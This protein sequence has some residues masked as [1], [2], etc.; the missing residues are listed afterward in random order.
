[1]GKQIGH[2]AA[3]KIPEPAPAIKL[4]FAEGLIRAHPSHIFQS[5]AWVSTGLGG[6][7]AGCS[8]ATSRFYLGDTSQAAALNQIDRVPEVGPAALLHATLQNLFA[9]ANGLRKGSAF[10][11]GVGDR[12]FQVDVFAG[13]EGVTRCVRASGPAML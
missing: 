12:F 9:G 2:A 5:S 7:V 10:F 4:F 1:M 13:G 11:D 6:Q 3:A 8:S